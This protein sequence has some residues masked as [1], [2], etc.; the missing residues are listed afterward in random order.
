[1]SNET[2]KATA[3]LQLFNIIYSGLNVVDFQP[4]VDGTTIPAQP[5]SVG[6]KVPMI[7]GS[8]ANEGGLF[9][10]GAY[11]SPTV[12]P[13]NYTTFLNENF[14]SAAPL[15]AKQYPLTLPAFTVPGKE[16]SPASPAFLAVSTIITDAQFTCPLY[17]AL[18]KAKANNIPVYSYF[19][20]HVP[21][22]PWVT[23]PPPEGLKLIGATHTS[24]IPFIFGNSAN[25]P[26]SS[27]NGTCNFTAAETSISETLIAAWTS[28]AVSGNPGG[29]PQ[30][31]NSSSQGLLIG[32]NTTSIG[33][34]DYSF[35]QFWD[36]IDD[37]YLSF[38]NSTYG[39]NGTNGTGTGSG[40]GSGSG[41]GTKSGAE[42]GV[43][44]GVWGL[45]MV[46]GIAMSLLMG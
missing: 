41:A 22:C 25:Q 30:W 12:S 16:G 26:L 44:M 10:L 20:S 43:E 2:L 31:D 3:P 34:I 40:S 36:M 8:N 33:A 45:T 28:M 14:G 35:C 39:N 13:D 17:Q 19:N 21:T 18:L 32:T 46:V 15:V 5:W 6:P 7:M 11:M 24:D 1:V 38:T 4:H 23:F 42:K 37:T 27:P 29:W 9:A